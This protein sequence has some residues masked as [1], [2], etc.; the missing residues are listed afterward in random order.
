MH[1]FLSRSRFE[2]EN[3]TS[4]MH[5]TD[6]NK[7]LFQRN[8]TNAAQEHRHTLFD[9]DYCAKPFAFGPEYNDGKSRCRRDGR[10]KQ[11]ARPRKFI[12]KTSFKA[13]WGPGALL[14]NASR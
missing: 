10:S 5:C 6:Q 9:M 1:P 4:Q 8:A 11:V 2:N 12:S 13:D 3:V 14:V 7:V